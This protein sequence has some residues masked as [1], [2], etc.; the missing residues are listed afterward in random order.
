MVRDVRSWPDESGSPAERPARP[1][2]EEPTA[3]TI[4]ARPASFEIGPDWESADRWE[5]CRITRSEPEPIA[6]TSG[7]FDAAER[8]CLEESDA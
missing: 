4:F 6:C 7:N 3:P 8:A 1:T 5:L 2:S